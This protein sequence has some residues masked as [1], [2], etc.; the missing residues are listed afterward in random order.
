MIID[1]FNLHK[2][3]NKHR[4]HLLLKPAVRTAI[5]SLQLSSTSLYQPVILASTTILLALASVTSRPM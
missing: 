2:H 5:H 3:L 4:V 1:G